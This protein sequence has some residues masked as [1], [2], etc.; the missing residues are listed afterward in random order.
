MNIDNIALFTGYAVL[1]SSS[2]ILILLI[3]FGVCMLSN[4]LQNK[5]M[6]TMGGWNVFYEFRDWYHNVK[7]KK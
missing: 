4:R 3:L 6:E 5:I 2:V 7:D 1:I